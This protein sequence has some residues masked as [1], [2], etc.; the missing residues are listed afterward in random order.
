MKKVI[1]YVVKEIGILSNNLQSKLGEG[2]SRVQGGIEQG[3][4]K[5]QVVQEIS[6]LKKEINETSMKKSK[7]LLELG[8]STYKKIR[9][10]E[11]VDSELSELTRGIVGL[12]HIVYQSSKKISELHQ[13]NNDSDILTCSSCQTPN[14]VDAKFCGGC[15]AKMEKEPEADA[16]SGI[17]CVNCDEVLSE[18]ANFCHCCGTK[19]DK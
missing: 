14:A 17:S 2:L 9:N 16:S 10:G 1:D 6:K 18:A 8:Q 15:G 19:V 13:T 7:I 12:D 3:K 4:L 11:I 5:L